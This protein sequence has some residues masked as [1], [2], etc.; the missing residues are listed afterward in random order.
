MEATFLRNSLADFESRIGVSL[1]S[2][3]L[4]EF[5]R[6]IRTSSLFACWKDFDYSL[7]G[8]R[9]TV[10]IISVRLESFRTLL[11]ICPFFRCPFLLTYNHDSAFR[12][13]VFPCFA[14]YDL[15]HF[16]FIPYWSDR[17]SLFLDESGQWFFTLF[18]LKEIQLLVLAILLW[19]LLVSLHLFLPYFLR[20][21]PSI[22][23][24]FIFLFRRFR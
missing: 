6:N 7:L 21:L 2:K 9:D 5:V 8:K 4:V 20:F 19:P 11:R 22:P 16:S 23:H 17:S 24:F 10:K 14:R 15:F 1:S 12:S 18:N 13:L 3:F